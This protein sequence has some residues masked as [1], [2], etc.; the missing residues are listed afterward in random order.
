MEKM[1]NFI[2]RTNVNSQEVSEN[3]QTLI[4]NNLLQELNSEA[5][6]IQNILKDPKILKED[7]E[8]KYFNISSNPISIECNF[9]EL[10][11][12]YI[13]SPKN[14]FEFLTWFKENIFMKYKK[15]FYDFEETLNGFHDISLCKNISISYLSFEEEKFMANFFS[16][17][18]KATQSNINYFTYENIYNI[19]NKGKKIFIRHQTAK[20]ITNDNLINLFSNKDLVNFLFDNFDEIIKSN[21]LILLRNS[22][23]FVFRKITINRIFLIDFFGSLYLQ[24]CIPKQNIKNLD[25]YLSKIFENDLSKSKTEIILHFTS[26]DDEIIKALLKYNIYMCIILDEDL[27][28][29]LTNIIKTKITYLYLNP[30]KINDKFLKIFREIVDK[31][32]L[33]KEYIIYKND[34]KVAIKIKLEENNF[35][36]LLNEYQNL[37]NIY[38]NYEHTFIRNSTPSKLLIYGKNNEIVPSIIYEFFPGV[39]EVM[40][41]IINKE[42]YFNNQKLFESS[43]CFFEKF[44][45]ALKALSNYSELPNKTLVVNNKKLKEEDFEKLYSILINRTLMIPCEEIFLIEGEYNEKEINEMKDNIKP[46]IYRKISPKIIYPL[47]HCIKTKLRNIYRKPILFRLSPFLEKHLLLFKKN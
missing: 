33:S 32:G 26:Y 47:F 21:G 19:V 11:E 40:N 36:I 1:E 37:H 35:E 42:K 38:F 5:Q 28:F 7:K 24:L 17:Y 9:K 25:N 29:L 20:N 10:N 4:V 46:I 39:K 16:K 2:N 15:Y 8:M 27:G 44:S 13:L 14:Y 45:D 6:T 3:N 41:I 18:I 31:L 22:N 34:D 23:F 12:I 43:I 30:K